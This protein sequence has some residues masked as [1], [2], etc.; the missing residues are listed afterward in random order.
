ME[1]GGLR[2]ARGG[3]SGRSDNGGSGNGTEVMHGYFLKYG[4]VL[5]RDFLKGP[6]AGAIVFSG[7]GDRPEC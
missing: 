2:R 4:L 6:F 5:R 7:S 1:G 3:K